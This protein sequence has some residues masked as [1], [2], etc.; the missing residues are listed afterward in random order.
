MLFLVQLT[1]FIII[2]QAHITNSIGTDTTK[3][4]LG[5]FKST[6][7]NRLSHTM[8]TSGLSTSTSSQ[9][10]CS[11]GIFLTGQF[12]SSRKES[13]KEN[14]SLMQ[15]LQLHLPCTEKG[16]K[17]CINRCL[18]AIVKHLP[19]AQEV[20][21]AMTDRDCYRERAYL[22]YQNCSPD[23]VNTNL[24]AGKEF[25]CVEGK[26][27]K[28]NSLANDNTQNHKDDREEAVNMLKKM[29]SKRSK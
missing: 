24:S 3:S 18:D 7:N 12:N 28:C 21:C 26:S 16:N 5:K 11:C 25:C 6:R 8:T 13:P 10:P 4:F 27:V 14:P 23:W 17:M 15:E 20:V 22:F 29:K 2:S 1:T 9:Y 19:N